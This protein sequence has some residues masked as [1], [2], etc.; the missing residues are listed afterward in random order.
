MFFVARRLPLVIKHD[1][2]MA[3]GGFF[4]MR[5]IGWEFQVAFGIESSAAA[6]KALKALQQS[7]C[8]PLNW[9][10]ISKGF[11]C[12]FKA[13]GSQRPSPEAAGAPKGHSR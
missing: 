11:R 7:G 10:E 5:T 6:S 12:T 9:R 13:H 8:D 1:R 4:A 3:G 2:T